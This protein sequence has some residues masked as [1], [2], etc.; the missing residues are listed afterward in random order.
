MFLWSGNTGY[1]PVW[2]TSCDPATDPPPD[3]GLSACSVA[4]GDTPRWSPDMSGR[5]VEKAN[6]V[7]LTDGTKH[8]TFPVTEAQ[9]KALS[10]DGRVLVSFETPQN[11]V[12]ALDVPLD[13]PAGS[14]A[15]GGQQ[16]GGGAPAAARRRTPAAATRSSAPRRPTA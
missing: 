8:L 1:I 7:E 9:Q 10:E 12:Q 14:P 5:V 13:G 3:Y 11:E 6:N 16:P 4:D 2:T 15:Q